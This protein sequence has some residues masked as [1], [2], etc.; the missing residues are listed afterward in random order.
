MWKM[1]EACEHRMNFRV[2]S[3]P[4]F[5][6]FVLN[7]EIPLA[8]QPVSSEAVDIFSLSTGRNQLRPDIDRLHANSSASSMS[9]SL[10]QSHIPIGDVCL[11]QRACPVGYSPP[12]Q[13][14]SDIS[15]L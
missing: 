7:D 3:V 5:L 9:A 15:Q 10:S 12:T 4:T 1:M 2:F 14:T 11:V 13:S 6:H 8:A